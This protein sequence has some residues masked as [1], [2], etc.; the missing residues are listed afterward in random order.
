MFFFS[1]LVLGFLELLLNYLDLSVY[2]FHQIRN[3]FGH[4][5][6][7]HFFCLP[8]SCLILGDFNYMYIWLLKVVPQFTEALFTFLVFAVF[9]IWV[10]CWDSFCCCLQVHWYFFCNVYCVLTPILLFLFLDIVVLLS[11]SLA[12][13]FLYLPFF[14]L[15]CSIFLVASRAQRM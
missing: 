2:G 13:A 15:V 8:F 3:N 12:W 6:F 14:Y 1:F 7:R 4:Y 10:A 9:I 11:K 5:F